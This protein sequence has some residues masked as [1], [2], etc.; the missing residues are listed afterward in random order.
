LRKITWWCRRRPLLKN[1]ANTGR[2]AWLARLFP[3]AKFVHIHRHPFAVVR[4]NVHLA[5]HGLVV[6]QLQDP[7]PRDSYETRLL[8]RYRRLIDTFYRDAATLTPGDVA[9]VRFEDL[10][11]DPVAAIEGLYQQLGLTMTD[12]FRRRL[13]AYLNHVAG[14]RKNTFDELP[15]EERACIVAVMGPYFE[16]W[17]YDAVG[18]TLPRDVSH[19]A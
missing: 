7:D 11:H 18:A 16:R 15:A 12:D 17:G 1:P 8:P 9:D 4:S 14:Y 5:Q 2:V 13:V 10:E 19:A 6:F 3:G